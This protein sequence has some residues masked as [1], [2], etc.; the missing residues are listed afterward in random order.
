MKQNNLATFRAREL[1]KNPT[2]AEK[3]L[4]SHLRYRQLRGHRFR[5]QRPIGMYIVDFVC[6]ES[7]LM[8][9]LDGG[10]HM[11]T[12]GYDAARTGGLN[13]CGYVVIRFCNN[14]VLTEM[15][16]VRETIFLALEEYMEKP[17]PRP[18]PPPCV[19]ERILLGDRHGA[20]TPWH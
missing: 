14:Q 3:A 9:E 12:H 18:N 11:K 1:R 16:G 5:R 17:S 20:I 7:R 15:D 10:Q 13:S 6:L 19:R 2:E 8:I 4:W